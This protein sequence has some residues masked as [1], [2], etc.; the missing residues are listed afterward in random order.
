MSVCGLTRVIRH[1]RA[2]A[3]PAVSS[4]LGRPVLI[5][6]EFPVGHA[7]RFSRF[8]TQTL[9]LVLFVRIE[10][11]FEPEPTWLVFVAFPGQDVGGDAVKEHPVVRNHDGATG[12]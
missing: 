2:P 1:A 7:V 4:G 6:R 5:A 8:W 11:A 3:I 12:E 10:V 9:D